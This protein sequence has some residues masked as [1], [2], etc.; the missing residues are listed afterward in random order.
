MCN[1]HFC[2]FR[3]LACLLFI[4]HSLLAV[5]ILRLH[6]ITNTCSFTRSA[7]FQSWRIQEYQKQVDETKK[8]AF[9]GCFVSVAFCLR[10]L[11]RSLSLSLV[12]ICYL[13]VLLWFCSVF[14]CVPFFRFYFNRIDLYIYINMHEW[15]RWW[16]SVA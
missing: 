6:R 9:S 1:T 7:R 5:N 10:V 14:I 2:E 8:N 13:C 15:C 11:V 3:F 12:F 16:H 4:C